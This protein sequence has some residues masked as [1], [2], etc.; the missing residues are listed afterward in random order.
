VESINRQ[1][2]PENQQ[3]VSLKPL[4]EH[5][6]LEDHRQAVLEVATATNITISY[7]ERGLK[8]P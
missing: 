4:V 6:Y 1:S 8:E 7:Q 2:V 5:V 3:L